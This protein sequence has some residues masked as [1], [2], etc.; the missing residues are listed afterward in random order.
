M[1]QLQPLKNVI[2]IAHDFPPEGNAGAYRPLRF[3]RHLLN[4]DWVP[5]VVSA[6][7]S[8]YERYDPA[9]LQSVPEEVEVIRIQYSDWWQGFQAWRS[10]RTV[11]TASRGDHKVQSAGKLLMEDYDRGS[12]IS[13]VRWK[14][15]GITP[16]WRPLG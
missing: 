10:K 12:G 7:P 14:P 13:S 6:T 2:M 3:A 9:L 16:I 4:H 8:Q 11:V 1:G 5:T 15:I